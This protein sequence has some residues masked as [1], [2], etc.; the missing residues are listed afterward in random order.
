MR[1]KIIDYNT[2]ISDYYGA[3]DFS[4]FL[5]SIAK[6]QKPKKIIELGSGT[7]LLTLFLAEAIENP[8]HIW[9]FDK[10]NHKNFDH[11]KKFA[12][13][14]KIKVLE[15]SN[16]EYLE[17]LKNKFSV[18]DKITF[19]DKKIDENQLEKIDPL[20][21]S[22]SIDMVVSDINSSPEFISKIL[23]H[24]LPK[25][26]K[27]SSFFFDSLPTNLMSYL[28]V[29]LIVEKMNQGKIPRS[30][31]DGKSPS[32]ITSIANIIHR[33]TFQLIPI[34][35]VK[36]RRQNSGAWLRISPVDYLSYPLTSFYNT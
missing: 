31:I 4:Y 27:S 20:I 17:S 35:E 21:P 33:S 15:S 30:I 24:F 5:Y 26:S 29:N 9:S 11:F 36:Q 14:N 6:M 12:A 10:T 25:M 3:E 23:S 16:I 2:K 8:A 28:S 34:N 22:H 19:F 18:S 7:G 32:E 1:K 13:A